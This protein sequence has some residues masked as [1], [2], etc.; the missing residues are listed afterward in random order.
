MKKTMI[1]IVADVAPIIF[2]LQQLLTDN[3]YSV[4]SATT[5]DQA[6]AMLSGSSDIEI[7]V[8]DLSLRSADGVQLLRDARRIVRM[9]DEGP[10][11]PPKFIFMSLPNNYSSV[12]ERQLREKAMLMSDGH[13]IDKPIDKD[14]LLR[15]IQL[16][17]GGIP[18]V[19]LN[20][21]KWP[22]KTSSLF[23][24]ISNHLPAIERIQEQQKR[25]DG[26]MFRLDGAHKE[27]DQRVDQL[28]SRVVQ[29][30]EGVVP[31]SMPAL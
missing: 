11:P 31:A 18:E 12:P 21:V 8:C 19:A 13:V 20:G 28:Q 2:T 7:V 1:L 16:L 27:L 4:V 3:G 9:N 5:G 29:L 23:T 15:R 6:L 30:E 17:G 10:L 25:L 26:E 22:E 24:S 14:D